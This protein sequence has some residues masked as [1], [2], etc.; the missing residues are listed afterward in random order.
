[1][2]ELHPW[3]LG[4]RL[5]RGVRITTLMWVPVIALASS[6][7]NIKISTVA[8][9]LLT[10]WFMVGWLGRLRCPKDR[11]RRPFVHAFQMLLAPIDKCATCGASDS[12][13][14]ETRQSGFGSS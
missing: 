5:Q 7:Y 2:T 6:G 13:L 8:P 1:M 4:R 11:D 3:R 14:H 10:N 9:L 12:E